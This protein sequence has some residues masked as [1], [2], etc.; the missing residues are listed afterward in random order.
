L[1]KSRGKSR[2]KTNLMVFIRPTILKDPNDARR[3]SSNRYGYVRG[4]QLIQNPDQEP[5]L[6]TLVRDYLGTVPPSVEARPDDQIIYAPGDMPA[7][8]DDG[9]IEQTPLPA[10]ETSGN[11]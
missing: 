6:D 11:P 3:F 10:S 9:V 1:F 8:R 4:R 5:S 7:V 2:V